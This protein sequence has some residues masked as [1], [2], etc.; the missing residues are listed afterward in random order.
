[1]E[2]TAEYCLLAIQW[3]PLC[4]PR[5]DWASWI[6]AIGSIIAIGTAGWIA[7]W[8]AQKQREVDAEQTRLTML[9]KFYAISALLTRADACIEI[10]VRVVNA[11]DQDSWAPV[12]Y[13][14][15]LI[16][17]KLNDLPVFELPSWK[18]VRELSLV[19]QYLRTMVDVCSRAT[20]LPADQV[21]GLAAAATGWEKRLS[22]V[23]QWCYSE[24]ERLHT[25]EERAQA[26]AN[27]EL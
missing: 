14:V 18:L 2:K 12:R 22:E 24:I 4:M 26:I 23:Q 21:A 11:H 1:M 7:V 16:R 3:W 6:Q 17:A 13:E 20:L 9:E 5:S 15:E 25:P 19:D 10:F 27:G 8:Q